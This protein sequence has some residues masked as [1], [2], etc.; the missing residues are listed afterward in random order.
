MDKYS[1]ALA[2][3]RDIKKILHRENAWTW[4][5][6]IIA[7]EETLVDST[8]KAAAFSVV[9]DI[10]M[11]MCKHKEGFSDYYI[12]RR[13]IAERDILNVE[14]DRLRNDLKRLLMKN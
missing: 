10:Y 8:D 3:L 1:E 7:C 2:L 11:N 4:E 5:R 14:L 12:N 6:L 9:S 13:N